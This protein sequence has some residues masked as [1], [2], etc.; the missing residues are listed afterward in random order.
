M[1]QRGWLK[2]R[3]MTAFE[4]KTFFVWRVPYICVHLTQAQILPTSSKHVSPGMRFLGLGIGGLSHQSCMSLHI[5]TNNIVGGS[6]K[7]STGLFTLGAIWCDVMGRHKRRAA[8]NRSR[9]NW[10]A[11]PR[12]KSGSAR[13]LKCS[14]PENEVSRWRWPH[15][16]IYSQN[17]H[18][19]L[20][21]DMIYQF[22]GMEAKNC[23]FGMFCQQC[24]PSVA[25]G[26]GDIQLRNVSRILTCHLF[27]S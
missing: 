14:G 18:F 25:P 4:W 2:K 15:S 17:D 12:P 10:I 19:G 8:R 27:T 11:G 3:L 7:K 9:P 21:Y 5:G 26:D 24:H 23:K 20:V 6:T 16:D 22:L 13:K 1:K